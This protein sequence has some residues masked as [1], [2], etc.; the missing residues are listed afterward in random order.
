MLTFSI[1]TEAHLGLTQTD[2]I[3]P[4]ANAIELLELDLVDALRT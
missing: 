1:V 2:G 3:L 4:L